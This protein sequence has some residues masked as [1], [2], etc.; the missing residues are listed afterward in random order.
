[1]G[2]MKFERNNTKE[3]RA[4]RRVGRRPS[5]V[6]W[7]INVH[8]CQACKGIMNNNDHLYVNGLNVIKLLH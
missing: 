6:S 2:S 4:Y 3:D 1:M 5:K 7:E 8:R